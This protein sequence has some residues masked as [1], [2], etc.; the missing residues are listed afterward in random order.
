MYAEDSTSIFSDGAK[1]SMEIDE[2]NSMVLFAIKIKKK[3][4]HYKSVEMRG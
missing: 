1:V 3:K 2:E 4:Q